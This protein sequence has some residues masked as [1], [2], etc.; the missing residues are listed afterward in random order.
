MNNIPVDILQVESSDDHNKDV[1]VLQILII[2]CQVFYNTLNSILVGVG[3]IF[4]WNS[5][6]NLKYKSLLI[7]NDR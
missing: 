4:S 7:T 6:P 3:L 5:Y 2:V 1:R